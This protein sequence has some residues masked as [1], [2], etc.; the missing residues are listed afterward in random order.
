MHWKV[1]MD[2]IM[3]RMTWQSI[4]PEI[5]EMLSYGHINLYFWDQF[6]LKVSQ[7]NYFSAWYVIFYGKQDSD[8]SGI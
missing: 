1:S 8:M 6:S 2:I 3:N 4:K 7:I 5:F